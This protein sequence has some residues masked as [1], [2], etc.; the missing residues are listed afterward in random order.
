[1]ATCS[2]CGNYDEIDENSGKCKFGNAK[3]YVGNIDGVHENII[4]GWPVVKA[5]EVACRNFE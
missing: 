2:E 3:R 5:D 1:M 4:N